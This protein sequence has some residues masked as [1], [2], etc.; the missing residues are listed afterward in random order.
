MKQIHYGREDFTKARVLYCLSLKYS[1]FL[2]W[3]MIWVSNVQICW[4]AS[5]FRAIYVF[6]VWIPVNIMP[7]MVVIILLRKW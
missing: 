7:V 5:W 2:S 6:F 1:C 4:K 3:S